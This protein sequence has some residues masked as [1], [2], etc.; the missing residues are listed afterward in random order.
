M[1]VKDEGWGGAKS[2]I[3]WGW[4]LRKELLYICSTTLVLIDKNAEL[5]YIPIAILSPK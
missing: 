1:A 4:A 2:G 3:K 5:T